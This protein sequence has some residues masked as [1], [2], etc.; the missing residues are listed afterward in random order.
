M[1]WALFHGERAGIK[2]H[3]AFAAATEQPVQVM[4]TIGTAHDGPIGEKLADKD[5]ILVNDCA[6]GKIKRFDH[7]VAEKQYVVTRIK[8]NVTLVKPRSL[9]NEKVEASNVVRDI[10]CYL[11]TP[12]CQSELRHRVVIFQNNNGHEIRVATNLMHLSAQQ[13]ADIYKAR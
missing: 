8:E 10:T 12:Q 9:K 11:G 2:L 4:E 7:Y 1:P 6:Y 13:I 3:V 5:Y